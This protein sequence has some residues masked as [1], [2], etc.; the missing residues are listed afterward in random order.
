MFKISI[1]ISILLAQLVSTAVC[2]EPTE[3]ESKSVVVFPALAKAQKEL[4]RATRD[5]EQLRRLVAR[6][7]GS[8]SELRRSLLVKRISK[9]QLAA[10]QKPGFASEYA[11]KS[12]ELRFEYARKEYEISR[13]L[14]R[15][16]SVS[17]LRHRKKAIAYKIAKVEFAVAKSEVEEEQ[18]DL[19]IAK[20]EVQQAEFEYQSAKRLFER[21]SL[22]R[23]TYERVRD[24]FLDAKANLE[25]LRFED[26]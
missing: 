24:R 17:E 12:A 20:L 6:G 7:S 22:K 3:A 8:N 16:G 11:I 14:Y 1:C 21:G 2:Q 15:R 9:L 10:I 25:D 4:K 19:R 5:Y 26:T 23:S 18:G 13:S